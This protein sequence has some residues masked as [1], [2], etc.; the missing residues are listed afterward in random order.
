MCCWFSKYSLLVITS[1]CLLYTSRA[2]TDVEWM[3]ADPVLPVDEEYTQYNAYLIY[4]KVTYTFRAGTLIQQIHDRIKVN[5]YAGVEEVIRYRFS[6]LTA[7]KILALDARTIK[8]NGIVVDLNAHDIKRNFYESILYPDAKWRAQT[9]SWAVPGLEPGDDFEII[10][11]GENLTGGIFSADIMPNTYL[12]CKMA[13]IDI[14]VGI[15]LKATIR[16]R[17]G[18]P[19]PMSTDFS[20]DNFSL[21][22]RQWTFWNLKNTLGHNFSCPKS[23]YPYLELIVLPERTF[24]PVNFT[25][26]S[27]PWD[28]YCKVLIE[29][30]SEVYRQKNTHQSYLEDYLKKMSASKVYAD[31]FEI[32]KAFYNHVM[33][34]I[35]IRDL[36]PVEAESSQGYYLYKNFADEDELRRLI[37]K[38]M[39]ILKLPIYYGVSREKLDGTIHEDF[40]PFHVLEEGFFAV[41]DKQ[42]V[43]HV[44]FCGDKS[45]K[46]FADEV[47]AEFLN[48]TALMARALDKNYSK[49]DVKKMVLTELDPTKNIRS[50]NARIRV[51]TEK[52]DCEIS[53]TISLSGDFSTNYRAALS[54]SFKPTT[55]Q[56]FD[57]VRNGLHADTL[58]PV[59]QSTG[60]P[61]DTKYSLTSTGNTL[62]HPVAENMFSIRLSELVQPLVYSAFNELETAERPLSFLFPF[63]FSDFFTYYIEFP[64]NV[65]LVNADILAYSLEE[66]F[67]KKDL[68]ITMVKPNII[69]VRSKLSITLGDISAE[70][71]PDLKDFMLKKSI[72]NSDL[73]L[74]IQ[75]EN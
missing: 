55:S 43:M 15:N 72:Y 67:G 52:L 58:I 18:A 50:T 45:G 66:E 61:Y 16:E 24:G 10:Y 21:V 4:H 42:G 32:F 25:A 63:T 14:S 5:T 9:I 28:F 60:F 1:S 20:T 62:I 51:L 57:Y 71:Y 49:I 38:A 34:T 73:L 36:I 68:S 56:Y 70:K 40:I 27:I 64:F 22:D 37:F 12:P 41:P 65:S 8:R 35:V 29:K 39:V 6:E 26:G 7:S 17:N 19:K 54:E 59:T 30:Y 46:Y 31:S 2:Q 75:K 74:L 33:D 3:N 53:G 48:A 23:T 69:S 13:R 44:F 47:P 11:S